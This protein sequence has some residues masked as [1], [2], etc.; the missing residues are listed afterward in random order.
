MSPCH[1]WSRSHI[2]GG[3]LDQGDFVNPLDYNDLMFGAGSNPRGI[4]HCCTLLWSSNL[5]VHPDFVLDNTHSW[6]G[7]GTR[8][9]KR[10]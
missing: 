4:E 5:I 1:L 2:T 6:E 9:I 10:G 8:M 3:S 7:W